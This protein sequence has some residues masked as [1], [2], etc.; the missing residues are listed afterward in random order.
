MD[1]TGTAI[2]VLSI[3]PCFIV[4][5]RYE[6]EKARRLH[7][8]CFILFLLSADFALK[9]TDLVYSFY[10]LCIIAACFSFL[11]GV[12]L[13]LKN[14]ENME[15]IK[16]IVKINFVLFGVILFYAVMLTII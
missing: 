8:Y 9:R 11:Y 10:S 1:I 4:N 12:P 7:K 6:Y 13:Y 16:N 5:I 3:V 15:A 14:K 2:V